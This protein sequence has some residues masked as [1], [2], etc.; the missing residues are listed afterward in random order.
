M[1]GVLPIE[2]KNL[3]DR[4]MVPDNETAPSY[5]EDQIRISFMLIEQFS[6]SGFG[7]SF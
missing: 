6:A 7:K 4:Y 2:N 3:I 1:L 5:N